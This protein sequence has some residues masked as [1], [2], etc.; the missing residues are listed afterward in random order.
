M[1]V[2]INAIREG[3]EMRTRGGQLVRDLHVLSDPLLQGQMIV[4]VVSDEMWTWY[5]D[6]GYEYERDR[7]SE[8]DLFLANQ[9]L[10]TFAFNDAVE[11]MVQ[12]IIDHTALSSEAEVIENA[13]RI[14]HRKVMK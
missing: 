8:L 7:E 13:I 10:R 12:D 4:G 6:G 1:T 3:R 14:M 9:R 11:R 2:I 5:Q